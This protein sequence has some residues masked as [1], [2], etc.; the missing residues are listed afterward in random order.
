MEKP[1]APQGFTPRRIT[2]QNTTLALRMM[3]FAAN[4]CN[5]LVG[6][7]VKLCSD[8]MQ[9]QFAKAFQATPS[10]RLYYCGILMYPSLHNERELDKPDRSGLGGLH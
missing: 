5:M 2:T 10:T 6:E 4:A 7:I 9:M 3:I 8:C 1:D